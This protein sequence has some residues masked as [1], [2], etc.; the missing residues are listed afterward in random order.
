MGI[1]QTRED[2]AVTIW[3]SEYK[4]ATGKERSIT[5]YDVADSDREKYLFVADAIIAGPL[6]E[7][8]P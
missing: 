5:W 1:N 6:K 3:L 2:I 4:R 7:L 8:L